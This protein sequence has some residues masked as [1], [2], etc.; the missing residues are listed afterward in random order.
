MA[1]GC[2]PLK[3]LLADTQ[4]V[5]AVLLHQGFHCPPPP[6]GPTPQ[7]RWL[8]KWHIPEN[9]APLLLLSQQWLTSHKT[10]PG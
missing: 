8:L 10:S 7:L 1:F 2:C 5:R 6:N 3:E 9:F 4:A